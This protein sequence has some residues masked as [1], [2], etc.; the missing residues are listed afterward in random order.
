MR[1]L[2]CYFHGGSANHGC[3]AIIRGTLASLQI[4]LDATL[5]SFNLPTDKKYNLDQ[6]ISLKQLGPV[7]PGRRYWKDYI[8]PLVPQCLL[9]WK[10]Q[11]FNKWDSSSVSLTDYQELFNQDKNALYLSVG[12]DIYCYPSR[13]TLIEMNKRLHMQ[14]KEM[15]LWGASIEPQ[16]VTL[17]KEDLSRY[18]KIFAR[19]S[20]T[21]QAL[22]DNGLQDKAVLTADPAFVMPFL[23]QTHLPPEFIPGNTIGINLSPMVL[24]LQTKND[25]LYKNIVQLVEYILKK[26]PYHIAFIPHVV[27][28]LGDDGTAMKTIYQKGKHTGRVCIIS[29][30]YNAMEL[31][32]I[33]SQCRFMVAARTHAS[34]AA[35]STQVPTLVIGYSVKARGIARDIFGTE[36]G[37]VLPVQGLKEQDE[38][39]QAFVNLMANEEKIRAHYK[40]FMPGYI[41]KTYQAGEEVKKLL[42]H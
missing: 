29:D 19:E 5:F 8:K 26:T 16:D 31:K 36:E 28:P 15:I 9:R 18:I 20:L 41:A 11:I 10:R 34:I 35:Y 32:G 25:I 37:Y 38:V 33:I 27:T 3:E 1:K 6:I 40:E 13:I 30:Q 14:H 23:I 4:P 21:Y 7:I 24:D 12:G 17:L 39:T 42:N 22:L 2:F